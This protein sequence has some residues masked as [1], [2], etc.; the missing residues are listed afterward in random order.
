TSFGQSVSATPLQ[1][2]SALSTIS[3]EGK[4]MRPYIISKIEE[5]EETI[6]YTPQVFSEP[7]SAKNAALVAQMMKGVVRNGEARGWFNRE[8]PGYD[9]AGKTGTAQIPKKNE[10]GYYDDRTNATFVG[11]SPTKNAKVI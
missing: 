10:A 4:R 11:F 7:I 9:I 8:L 1:I 2:L 5:S 6:D 3:N